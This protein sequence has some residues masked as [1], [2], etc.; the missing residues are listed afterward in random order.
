[1]VHCLTQ[2]P[3][4]YARPPLLKG[5][6]SVPPFKKGGLGGISLQ[7]M[8]CTNVMWSDLARLALLCRQSAALSQGRRSRPSSPS[9]SLPFRGGGR[10]SAFPLLVEQGRTTPLIWL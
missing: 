10:G 9:V 7:V 3:P 2:I 5:A 6:F 8:K 1:L 4:R